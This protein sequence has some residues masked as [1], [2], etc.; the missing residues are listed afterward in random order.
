LRAEAGSSDR[1]VGVPFEID[2]GVRP[3][4]AYVFV[5]SA[6]NWMEQKEAKLA[7]SDA[8]GDEFGS[9]VALLA[10]HRESEQ[11]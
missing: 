6:S 2:T 5:R 3:G 9:S 1:R 11:D 4:S 7:A 10:H 8:G